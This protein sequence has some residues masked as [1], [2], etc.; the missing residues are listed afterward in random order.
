MVDVHTVGAGGG[1]IGWADPGRRAARRTAIR[2]RR[3]RARPATGAEARSRPSPTRTSLLGY[4]GAGSA[5][6]G[7][8]MLD[9]EAA[10]RAVDE[11]G[12]RLG[13]DRAETAWGIVRVA[14]QEM[15]RAL[16]VVTVERGVDPRGYALVA[17]GGAGPDARGPDRRGARDRARAL[18]ARQPASCRRWAGRVRPPARPRA[19]RAARG[20]RAARG[21]AARQRWPS[22][23][24]AP[25][26]SCPGARIEVVLRPAL[27]RAGVRADRRRA[28]RR[29][30][31]ACCASGSSAAHEER[32]GYTD[33]DGEIELVNVRVAAVADGARPAW[34]RRGPAPAATSPSASRPARFGA[35]CSRPRVVRGELARG[36]RARGPRGLRAAGGDGRRSARLARRRRVGRR[37]AGATA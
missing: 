34:G 12:R 33:P 8:V 7:G 9:A 18:P 29:D 22:S 17:F 36:R 31:A 16:R 15:L 1:S 26:R 21:R 37:H 3:A 35:E 14:D 32:Y 24:H 6:A 25:A 10:E 19:K 2:G 27:P 28:A 30:P 23:P 4:L 20:A 11:L 5:L 13:L